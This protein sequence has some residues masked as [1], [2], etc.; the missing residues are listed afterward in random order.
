VRELA[1]DQQETDEMMDAVR[2]VQK[3]LAEA[4][5]APR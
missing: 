5:Y 1:A 2:A 3:G 4:G